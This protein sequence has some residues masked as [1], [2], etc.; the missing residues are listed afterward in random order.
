VY[1]VTI[2]FLPGLGHD[3][4]TAGELYS[5]DE[6]EAAFVVIESGRYRIRTPAGGSAAA[7]P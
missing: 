2:Q 7:D 1:A 4:V 6:L 5:Y 3:V